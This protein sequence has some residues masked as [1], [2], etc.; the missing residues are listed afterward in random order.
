[1]VD[2]NGII[3]TLAGTGT[4]GFNGDTATVTSAMLSAPQGLATYKG[5]VF[6]CDSGNARLRRI[7]SCS[8]AYMPRSGTITGPAAACL[9]VPILLA[10]TGAYG[11]I[12]SW[13][14]SDTTIAKIAANGQVY[15]IS[16]GMVTIRYVV[17]N[18]CGSAIAVRN[19][20]VQSAPEPAHITG[21][22]GI[23]AGGTGF[24]RASVAGGIWHS[25]GA[26]ATVDSL[27]GFVVTSDTGRAIITYTLA[28][29]CGTASTADT[30]Q[31]QPFPRLNVTTT[32]TLCSGATFNFSP[33]AVPATAQLRW[34]RPAVAGLL[35]AADTG[36]GNISEL[37]INTSRSP[38]TVTYNYTLR[39]AYCSNIE[40]VT[41]TVLP[42]PRLSDTATKY[43]CSGNYFEFAPASDLA[44]TTYAWSRLSVA[45]I[46]PDVGAGHGNI[47]ETLNN[48]TSGPLAA[49][50][51]FTL[52]AAGCTDT[53]RLRVVVDHPAA[54]HPSITTHPPFWLC[55]GTMFQNFGTAAIPPA[56]TRFTWSASGAE[57]FATGQAG[58]YC[59]VN[60]PYLGTAYVFL[61]AKDSNSACPSR[62]TFRVYVEYA[63]SD[64]PGVAYLNGTFTS[65]RNDQ[66][67]YQWGYDDAVTLD[68][69]L[70]PG[71]TNQDYFNA[72]PDWN[73][74]YY[75]VITNNKWCMRKDYFVQPLRSVLVLPVE[76][77]VAI[78]PNPASDVV[79][80]QVSGPDRYEVAITSVTGSTIVSAWFAG[81][82]VQ[83]LPL[84]LP[85]G[86][87]FIRVSG[88]DFAKTEKLL[89]SK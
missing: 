4:P 65:L 32:H 20:A 1:M 83:Q 81:K 87:Y 18:N 15:P 42:L 59:L 5:M 68:S 66:Y 41:L 67:S 9:G 22:T 78:F 40:A 51:I 75:W 84:S 53:G 52:T 7:D 58:R 36:S 71:E 13:S 49:A 30:L 34:S 63:D 28:N 85:D 61:S 89:I 19:L 88:T 3:V 24:M 46:T 74:K 54:A 37:L 55:T 29:S 39:T 45:G 44:A 80:F 60:F 62:D 64:E 79:H 38:V 69:T 17:A 35:N 10:D 57:V 76:A 2:W 77:Q 86:L 16:T 48:T 14:S 21:L 25:T 50:Y 27:T 6:V 43:T 23:C 11:N 56:G 72:H 33:V 26:F 31:V 12:T 70:L 82:E 8:V 47:G 73:G